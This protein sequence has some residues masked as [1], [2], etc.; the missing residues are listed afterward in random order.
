[1]QES[2]FTKIIRR[3]IPASIIYEDEHT[4]AIPDKFPSMEGQ[5]LV[6]SKRQV[7]YVGDL[8]DTEYLALMMTT[9]KILQALDRAF[10]TTRTCFIVEGFEVPH[11]HV[12]LYPCTQDH[13]IY[14]PRHEASN[15]TLETLTHKIK[16]A[17]A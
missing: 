3:E 13:I 7:S 2:I 10:H 9:K 4:I 6:I 8:T 15:E 11:V 12:R 17:L 1:M 16:N 5:V 14:E